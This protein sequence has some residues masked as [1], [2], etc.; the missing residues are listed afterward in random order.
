MRRHALLVISSLTISACAATTPMQI[1][2]VPT[3]RTREEAQ[4]DNLECSNLSRTNGPWLYGIGTE[5]YKH[6]SAKKYTQCMEA[7]GYQV[8]AP[9]ASSGPSQ[10]QTSPKPSSMTN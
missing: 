4:L 5:I 8:R 3:G 1:T 6:E 2:R 9:D 10:A 7:R